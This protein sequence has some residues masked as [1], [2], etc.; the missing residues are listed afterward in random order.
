MFRLPAELLY[1]AGST[2]LRI[3]G[4]AAETEKAGDAPME[5]SPQW[6]EIRNTLYARQYWTAMYFCASQKKLS[7]YGILLSLR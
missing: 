3:H 6:S 5:V 4:E 2:F 7:R 1:D